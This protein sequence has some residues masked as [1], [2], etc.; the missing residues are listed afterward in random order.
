MCRVW[1]GNEFVNSVITHIHTLEVQLPAIKNDSFQKKER[2]REFAYLQ[3]LLHGRFSAD[4]S[5]PARC[6]AELPRASLQTS[7][8]TVAAVAPCACARGRRRTDT[9]S[10][11]NVHV[12]RHKGEDIRVRD[13]MC[14]AG[15]DFWQHRCAGAQVVW[16]LELDK[17]VRKRGR[18]GTISVVPIHTRRRLRDGMNV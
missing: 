16:S 2:K 3:R 15:L 11:H 8:S 17:T 10:G 9:C 13:V 4:E 12:V 1:G 5:L 14:D 18:E 7:S 6:S